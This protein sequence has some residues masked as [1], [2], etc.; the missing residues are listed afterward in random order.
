MKKIVALLIVVFLSQHTF[1]QSSW[2]KQFTL[3]LSLPSDLGSV[4]QYDP[5]LI[6]NYVSKNTIYLTYKDIDGSAFWKDDWQ[7]AYMYTQAGNIILLDKAKMNLYSGELHYLTEDGKELVT[8]TTAVAKV[9]FMQKKDPSKVDAVFAVLAN[10]VDN[11]PAAYFK[12]FNSGNYQLI[13]LEQRKV[14]TSPYDPIQGKVVSS[15]YATNHF[16][17][18]NNGKMTPLKDL[19][20]ATLLNMLPSNNTY[21]TWLKEHKNKLK[22]ESE[23]VAFLQYVNSLN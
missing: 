12:V 14:K 20:K 19:D 7:K 11:K 5:N 10:Y 4:K 9:V 22:N 23:A 13:L 6:Q 17:I 21:E 2:A 18:Y 16:A 15:F 8:E 3:D 1:A